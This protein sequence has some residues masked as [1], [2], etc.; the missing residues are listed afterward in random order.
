MSDHE[1]ALDGQKGTVAAA[2]RRADAPAGE[3]MLW[4]AAGNVAENYE[5][6]L[7]PAIFEPWA[8]DLLDLAA[9]KLGER[10]LDVACGTGIVARIAAEQVGP[11][12]AVVGVDSNP[13]ML[14]VARKAFGSAKVDLRE[15]NAA[16]LP[17]GNRTFDVV[18]C[19][20][21]LQFFADRPAAMREMHRVLVPGGR[22][23]VSCWKPIHYS[24][25][26]V[27]LAETLAEHA[28][29]E[30]V[31]LVHG[32]FTLGDVGELRSLI[33]NAGFENT[34][35]YDGVR[36]LHFPS[37][38]EFVRRYGTGSPLAGI[39]AKLSA[40]AQAELVRDLSARIAPY[41]TAKELAFPIEAHLALAYAGG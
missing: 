8:H 38:E 5:R 17:L 25:G 36:T 15:G 40:T 19:Q 26:F 37:C 32:P 41:V 34:S 29:P 16:T 27:A 2:R 30:A 35:T 20:Q 23:T 1:G 3:R 10:V 18:L 11:L 12:G 31:A 21:G 6:Y 7:V 39:L 33:V 24:P 14:V 13:D 4:Q 9:P 22:L 28:G